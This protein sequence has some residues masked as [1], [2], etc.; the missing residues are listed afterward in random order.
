MYTHTVLLRSNKFS[1]FFFGG[2]DVEKRER[3]R[4]SKKK[5]NR[6]RKKKEE[7]RF[8]LWKTRKITFL[9]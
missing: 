6:E 3:E 9:Q 4:E 8:F 1:T 7:K 5:G 2:M